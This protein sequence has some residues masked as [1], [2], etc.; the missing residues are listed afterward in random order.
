MLKTDAEFTYVSLLS[1][2]LNYVM[3]KKNSLLSRTML[4]TA[5]CPL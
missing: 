2:K 3:W 4:A 1:C 5:K